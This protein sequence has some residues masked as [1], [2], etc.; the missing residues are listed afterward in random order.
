MATHSVLLQIAVS[1]FKSEQCSAVRIGE[2]F[3]NMLC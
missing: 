2:G 1:K 3:I